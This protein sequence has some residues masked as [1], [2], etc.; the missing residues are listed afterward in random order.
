ME[1]TI[2]PTGWPE[3]VDGKDTGYLD[4]VCDNVIL[5][6]VSTPIQNPLTELQTGITIPGSRTGCYK[7]SLAVMSHYPYMVYG[8]TDW[9]RQLTKAP[10]WSSEDQC[11]LVGLVIEVSSQA[12]FAWQLQPSETCDPSNGL[13]SFQWGNYVAHDGTTWP[14]PPARY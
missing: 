3:T 11:S 14:L 10:S 6:G 5:D 9:E 7:P 13:N 1:D 2:S 8:R 12:Y 4:E